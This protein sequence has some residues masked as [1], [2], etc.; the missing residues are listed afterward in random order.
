MALYYHRCPTLNYYNHFVS[1]QVS[2]CCSLNW[3][4]IISGVL[5]L[6]SWV[7]SDHIKCPTFTK[8]LLCVFPGVCTLV[9]PHVVPSVS[10]PLSDISLCHFKCFSFSYLSGY[11]GLQI[12]HC[13]SLWWLW[14][15]KSK[16]AP[17]NFIFCSS[18]AVSFTVFLVHCNSCHHIIIQWQELWNLLFG[19]MLWEACMP[20]TWG[21][22]TNSAILP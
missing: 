22:W 2:N 5:L 10:L 3:L 1:S 11:M 9:W 4:H 20:K 18:S 14:Y 21:H 17:L 7:S 12:F 6:I 8:R 15:E 19:P 16:A 13:H